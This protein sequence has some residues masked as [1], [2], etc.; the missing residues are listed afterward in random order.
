[1]CV[2]G[3]LPA[4]GSAEIDDAAAA[5]LGPKD[6]SGIHFPPNPLL[7]LTDMTHGQGLGLVRGARSRYCAE[8]KATPGRRWVELKPPLRPY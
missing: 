6:G 1:M 5:A 3:P 4:A 8:G 7:E 2:A